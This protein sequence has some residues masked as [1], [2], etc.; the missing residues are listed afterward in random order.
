MIKINTILFVHMN[1][2]ALKYHSFCPLRRK[3][4]NGAEGA[5]PVGS[6]TEFSLDNLQLM[7]E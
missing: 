1:K 4:H 3:F 2:T 7:F 5:T 6:N